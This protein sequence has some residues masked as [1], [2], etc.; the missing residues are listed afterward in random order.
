MGV[1]NR[2]G[3]RLEHGRRLWS[4]LIAAIRGKV[5]VG[6]RIA[7]GRSYS[8]SR[9]AGIDTLFTGRVLAVDTASAG[10]HRRAPGE[11]CGTSRE[12]IVLSRECGDSNF[13]EVKE[14]HSAYC[15]GQVQH[16]QRRTFQEENVEFLTRNGI[17][18]EER[19]LFEG[20]HCG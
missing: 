20:E 4:A 5:C 13:V 11:A 1:G 8:K 14:A 7:T 17:E 3:F 2:H 9:R 15:R 12:R 6:R 19:Y 16:H 10:S 18:F